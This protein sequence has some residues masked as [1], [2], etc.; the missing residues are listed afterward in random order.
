MEIESI[1]GMVHS[2]T[3]FTV[4][5]EFMFNTA[6]QCCCL[7]QTDVLRFTSERQIM[8]RAALTETT[9]RI[10]LQICSFVCSVSPHTNLG[11]AL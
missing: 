1:A 11:P 8:F 10:L 5:A 9:H 4:F 2:A 3:T 6:V 7:R